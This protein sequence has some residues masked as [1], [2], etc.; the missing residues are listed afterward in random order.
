MT[1]RAHAIE[2]L[3]DGWTLARTELRAQLRRLR[4][5]RRRLLATVVGV[6]GF[7][8]FLGLSFVPGS[9]AFGDEFGEA[10]PLGTAGLALWAVTL[11]VAYF[12]AASGFNQSQVGTVAALART[13]IPPRAVSLGRIVTQTVRA[14]WFIVPVG[15]LLLGGVAVGGGPLVA[16]AVLLAV[17]PPMVVGLFVGRVVGTVAR[18]GNERLQISMWVKALLLLGVM[19]AIFLGTQ[20]LLDARYETG[21][22]F[23]VGALVP[24]TPLQSY[25]AVVFAPFG[26]TTGPFGVVVTGLLLA[27]IPLGVVIALKLETYLLVSDLGSDASTTGHVEESYGVPRV[28]DASPTVRVG[29]RYLV[30]TRRDPRML[31]HLT[32]ILFGAFGLAGSAFQDPGLVLTIGPGATVVAGAVLAGSAYC[33]NPMG[34]DRDQ[35]PLLLTST[36]SVDVVLRGRMVAGGALGTVVALG[37]GTPLAVVEHDPGYVFG[38]SLLAVV[39]IV[40]SVGIA[41]GLGAI[42]PKFERNE[43]MNVERAHPSQWASLGFFFGGTIVAVIGFALLAVTLSGEYLLPVALGWLLYVSVLALASWGGYR[44]AVQ[45]FDAFTLDDI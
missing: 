30:R 11:A 8:A 3:R 10:V 35:L 18:Y 19:G 44:Y 24:G 41:V 27:A 23:A 15:A 33:L 9:I 17:L 7:G 21:T 12:G 29:W 14:T 28:F 39:L 42:A 5:D 6:L 43:Y 45:R 36:R 1:A 4:S 38:Q 13:S 22:Q 16:G 31:A 25:A 34:D 37:I 20:V 26:T 32:P 40:A 2:D